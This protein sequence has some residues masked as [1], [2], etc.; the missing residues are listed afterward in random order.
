M[1]RALKIIL[2]YAIIVGGIL[3][4]IPN[5]KTSDAYIR[6]RVVMLENEHGSCSG[7]QVKAPSK[8]VYIMTAGHC[9]VL[10]SADNTTTAIDEYGNRNTVRLVELDAKDDLMLLTSPNNLSIDI[11][12]TVFTHEKIHTLTHGDHEP[13]YRTDGE[14][15]DIRTV[16]IPLTF[17]TSP[18]ED[19]KCIEEGHIPVHIFGPIGICTMIL[20][21]QMT[22]A[23]VVPGSSGGAALNEQGELIG[24]VSISDG[25]HFSGVI[26]LEEIKAFISDK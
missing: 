12:D 3:A 10:L 24:I 4:L 18:A 22:S 17:S 25:G 26:P 13:T 6:D 21:E 23:W 20:S 19:Q 2:I 11:T 1:K 8:K 5:D 16:T 15:L 7:I 14:I 9:S